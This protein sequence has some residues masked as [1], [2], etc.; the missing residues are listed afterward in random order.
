MVIRLDQHVILDLTQEEASFLRELLCHY[1]RLY[2]AHLEKGGK[3]LPPELLRLHTNIV[4]S[5]P[6]T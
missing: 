4:L 2:A 1:E 5:V 6:R 3:A